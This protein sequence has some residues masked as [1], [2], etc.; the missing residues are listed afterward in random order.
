MLCDPLLVPVV[1]M[2]MER[3][4]VMLE[5]SLFVGLIEAVIAGVP[6]RD[7]EPVLLPV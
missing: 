1:L 2:V 6:V 3:L 5:V 4:L 7:T